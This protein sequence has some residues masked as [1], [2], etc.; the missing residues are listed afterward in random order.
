MV[1]NAARVRSPH[2]ALI[3]ALAIG[4]FFIILGAVFALTPGISQKTNTFFSDLTTVTFP[5]GGS[6]STVSLLAPANPAAHNGFYMAVVNFLLGIGILQIV[7]L[8]LRL[9]VK[10]PIRRIA[11]TVGNLIFWLGAAV[12]ANVFLL[13]GT[14]NGWFQFWSALIVLIGVSLIAQFFVYLTK[15]Q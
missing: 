1:G 5:F 12:M 7:I 15:R 6:G 10:S 2:E 13:T 3:T 14:L 9:W 4:G 8:A 11:E